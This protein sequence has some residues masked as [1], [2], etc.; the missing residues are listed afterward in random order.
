MES[1]AYDFPIY[2]G[3]AKG[4]AAKSKDVVTTDDE[5]IVD[6]MLDENGEPSATRPSQ[7][8]PRPVRRSKRLSDSEPE[9]EPVEASEP[10]S[11]RDQELSPPPQS[12]PPED[13]AAAAA[14]EAGAPA[15]PITAPRR[16]RA[17]PM[18]KENTRQKSPAANLA[19]GQARETDEED[20]E[21]EHGGDA[22]A[23][24]RPLRKR[25]RSLLDEEEEGEP[26]ENGQGEQ[27]PEFSRHSTPQ[28]LPSPASSTGEIKVRR[29]RARH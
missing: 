12:E 13:D 18:A 10:E 25:R 29:K 6:D 16:A 19:R 23:T 14:I 24:P 11:D 3:G 15:T 26:M 8:R 5:D 28:A 27:A 4:R 20:G 9:P 2:V 22:E 7:P 21:S 1:N 17:K